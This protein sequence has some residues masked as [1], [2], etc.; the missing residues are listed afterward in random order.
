MPAVDCRTHFLSIGPGKLTGLRQITD[1]AGRFKVLAID[2]IG[3]FQEAFKKSGKDATADDLRNGKLEMTRILGPEASSVLLDVT[4]A[5]RQALAS[6]ALPKGVGLVVRL[7]KGCK[8]GEYGYEEIG[9]NVG[10]IKRMGASAVKLLVYMDTSNKAYTDFQLDFVKRT[11]EQCAEHDILLMTEEL[12]FPRGNE[13]K[14]SPDYLKRKVDNILKSTE[15]LGPWTDILKLEFPGDDNLD[16][17]NTVA[18]RPWVLLSAGVDFDVFEKQVE[19][20]MKK[21]ASGIMAG[22]AIFKDWFRLSTPAERENFLKTTG[23]QR[24]RT[25]NALVDKYA[26]AWMDRCP[27]TPA[28]LAGAV[29]YDWYSP[30]AAGAAPRAGVY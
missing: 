6:A 23:L 19:A 26:T 4:F 20:A 9:W 7:E 8:A 14:D 17:L 12:S 16:R 10:K 18:I 21:G 1:A 29:K 22:R 24:M 15:L 11:C 30:T 28:D 25:L 5:A 27:I 2:Q 13:T 3:S